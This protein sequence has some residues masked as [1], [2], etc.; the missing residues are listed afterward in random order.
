MHT[1]DE[2]II[3]EISPIKHLDKI[4]VAQSFFLENNYSHFPVTEDSVYIGC[5]SR[6]DVGVFSKESDIGSHR[7]D[8]E[9]F[10]VRTALNWLDVLEEFAKNETNIM[11]VL[12]ANNQYI[13]F[14]EVEDVLKFFNATPFFKDEGGILVVK[15]NSADFSMSQIA[16]IVES[17]NAKLLGMF[18]SETDANFCE[19]TLKVSQ[20]GLNDIIQTFRRYAYEIVSEHQEDSYLENLKDRS[21]YLDKYLNI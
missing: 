2:Y 9:R 4:A 1:L 18:I 17:N 7:Y 12:N 11:P 19:V 13:G 8:F 20:S 6:E 14:Y 15:K 10:Y 5:V 3:T 16:Q 21:D